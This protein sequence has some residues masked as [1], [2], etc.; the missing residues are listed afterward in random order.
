PQYHPT[1]LF[2]VPLDGGI[3]KVSVARFD[4][5]AVELGPHLPALFPLGCWN[6]DLVPDDFILSHESLG[7]F[8][9]PDAKRQ[10]GGDVASSSALNGCELLHVG[11]LPIERDILVGWLG[12]C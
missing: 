8:L 12:V 7:E 11:T 2:R 1:V 3:G 9:G 10:A 5:S 6:P 4:V